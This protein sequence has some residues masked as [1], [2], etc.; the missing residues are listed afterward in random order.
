[1]KISHFNAAP[2]SAK[3]S[4][5]KQKAETENTFMMGERR[6]QRE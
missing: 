5:K 1:M 3:Q 6:R 4:R 2:F